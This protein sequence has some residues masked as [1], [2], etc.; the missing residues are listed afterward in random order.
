MRADIEKARANLD[1]AKAVAESLQHRERYL[2]LI[3]RYGR[4]LLGM[5]DRWLD[6]AEREL[7]PVRGPRQG[8]PKRPPSAEL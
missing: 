4:A 2:R 6:E 3:H 1:G 8:P 7:R 5:H